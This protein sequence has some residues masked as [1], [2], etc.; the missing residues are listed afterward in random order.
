MA[1]HELE[2]LDQQR[3]AQ[4]QLVVWQFLA[5]CALWLKAVTA[6]VHRI[7]ERIEDLEAERDNVASERDQLALRLTGWES[8]GNKKR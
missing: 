1:A 4:G 3:L 6:S 2:L 8:D 5:K 7:A